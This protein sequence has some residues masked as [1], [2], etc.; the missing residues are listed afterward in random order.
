MG[1]RG[2][3]IVLSVCGS[4]IARRPLQPRL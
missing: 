4:R 1:T 2:H 3:V